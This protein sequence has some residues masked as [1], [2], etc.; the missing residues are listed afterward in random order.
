MILQT[1]IAELE[2]KLNKYPNMDLKGKC[3]TMKTISDLKHTQ[4]IIIRVREYVCTD[5]INE[6]EKI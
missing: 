5:I 2:E 4:A 1:Y 6:M 3:I